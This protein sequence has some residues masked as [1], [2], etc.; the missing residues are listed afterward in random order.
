MLIVLS[1]H[2]TLSPAVN[3]EWISPPRG[4]C[5]GSKV[6]RSATANQ[7]ESTACV[8]CSLCGPELTW[9]P[10]QESKP[11]VLRQVTDA[12]WLQQLSVCLLESVRSSN[13]CRKCF[14]VQDVLSQQT[15]G[16]GIYFVQCSQSAG[17]WDIHAVEIVPS[18]V[19]RKIYQNLND[20]K[21]KLQNYC[22][23]PAPPIQIV[24]SAWSNQRLNRCVIKN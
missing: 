9:N 23:D 7:A 1:K 14:L 4:W 8:G 5:K 22:I 10:P 12:T 2:P 17:I 20:I 18:G 19:K 13:D 3:K 11:Y 24:V 15:L 16:L 21:R 6:S